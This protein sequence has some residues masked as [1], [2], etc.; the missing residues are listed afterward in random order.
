MGAV[1]PLPV[2]CQRVSTCTRGTNVIKK[3]PY[4]GHNKKNLGEQYAFRGFLYYYKFLFLKERERCIRFP[5]KYP[6]FQKDR[7][8]FTQD[9][10]IINN[11]EL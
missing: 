3:K 5:V 1:L 6:L 9:S 2:F 11:S 4:S 7:L 8:N 10:P